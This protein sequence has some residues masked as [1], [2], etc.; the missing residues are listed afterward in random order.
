M[1]NQ[2]IWIKYE[3]EK[4][5]RWTLT[6]GPFQD[7][8][9]KCVFSGCETTHNFKIVGETSNVDEASEWFKN[10]YAEVK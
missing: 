7:H 6:K 9:G 4:G 8:P 1:K 2:T 10:I 5:N 3:C